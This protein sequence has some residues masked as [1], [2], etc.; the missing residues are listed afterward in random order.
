MDQDQTGFACKDVNALL[1][2]S[3]VRNRTLDGVMMEGSNKGRPHCLI[4]TESRSS[5]ARDF[6]TVRASRAEFTPHNDSQA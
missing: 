1:E 2:M 5:E 4:L 6:E 3:M